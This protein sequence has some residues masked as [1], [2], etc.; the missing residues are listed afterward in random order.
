MSA[1]RAEDLPILPELPAASPQDSTPSDTAASDTAPSDTAP[2]DTAGSESAR[3]RAAVRWT[4]P[5][6]PP[7]PAPGQ[8]PRPQPSGDQAARPRP[9][10]DQA[11]RPETANPPLRLTRRGRVVV[12][13]AA[14][15]VLAALSLVIAS[16]AQATN[17]PVSSRAAQQGLAQVTVH[18]GQSLW[19]VAENADPAADTRVVIQQIIELNG[20]TGNVVFTGQ[21]LWVPRG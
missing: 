7:A 11:T 20:L 16:A 14:A 17:H 5:L 8:A 2:S 12:A 19:S 18:P 10:R 6:D 13:V 1:M 4:A 9:A 3:T 21:R 15:L